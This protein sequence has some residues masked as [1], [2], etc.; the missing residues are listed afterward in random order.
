MSKNKDMNP[1]KCVKGTVTKVISGGCGSCSNNRFLMKT[2]DGEMVQICTNM[3]IDVK[4]GD[5]FYAVGEYHAA[6]TRH[7]VAELKLNMKQD[8]HKRMKNIT[9]SGG[10]A[11]SFG[12]GAPAARPSLISWAKTS[13]INVGMIKGAKGYTHLPAATESL[14]ST[15]NWGR[16]LLLS[17]KESVGNNSKNT[18]LFFIDPLA[19]HSHFGS[20]VRLQKQL[21]NY[22][23][24]SF[25]NAITEDFAQK[26]NYGTGV[27]KNKGAV[28]AIPYNPFQTAST[29]MQNYTGLDLEYFAPRNVLSPKT[30]QQFSV[31][32]QMAAIMA[33]DFDR[34]GAEDLPEI[35][36]RHHSFCDA[37]AILALIQKTGDFKAAEEL[38]R[39]AEAAILTGNLSKATHKARLKAIETAMKLESQGKLATLSGADL[40]KQAAKISKDHVLKE[41]DMAE[42]SNIRSV[43]LVVAGVTTREN[44]KPTFDSNRVVIGAKRALE[45]NISEVSGQKAL[46]EQSL[47]AINKIAYTSKDME[48]KA[49]RKKA[50]DIYKK[51]L[52]DSIIAT[53]STID[54]VEWLIDNE[55]DSHGDK[56]RFIMGSGGHG[57]YMPRPDSIAGD[58]AKLLEYT[59]R[60]MEKHLDYKLAVEKRAPVIMARK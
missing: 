14:D 50:L 35:N 11:Y 27:L 6:G 59:P 43:L 46:I 45:L 48:N 22:A 21:R 52:K 20:A 39:H 31:A 42:I 33:D 15:L 19:F 55:M 56:G 60:K 34:S 5:D 54:N 4:V 18:Q 58:R 44:G 17:A 49:V 2:S 12:K 37:F 28:I 38:S 25:Y 8:A 3:S 36:N 40:M 1:V 9:K 7:K 41:K 16:D 51:D 13:L 30:R 26:T 10:K 29:A 32:Q 23:P 24:A 53:K 57:F 47:K